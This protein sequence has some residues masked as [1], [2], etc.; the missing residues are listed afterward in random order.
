MNEAEEQQYWDLVEQF[1]ENA[2]TA[3]DTLEPG[4]VGAA[5]LQAAARY[6]AFIVASASLDRKEFIADIEP[7]Q[8]HLSAAFS[9]NLTADLEDYRENY[10]VYMR[11]EDEPEKG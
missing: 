10:K 1:I 8:L 7:S 4:V 3:C 5:L 2:N 6:N 9:E 11:S